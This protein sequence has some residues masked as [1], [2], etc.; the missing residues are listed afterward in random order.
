MSTK[1][2]GMV[3]LGHILP[4]SLT[5]FLLTIGLTI[6]GQND[7]CDTITIVKNPIAILLLLQIPIAIL[8]SIAITIGS[9]FCLK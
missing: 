2:P 7:Y 9:I 6:A 5:G 4:H 3:H 1:I 8:F